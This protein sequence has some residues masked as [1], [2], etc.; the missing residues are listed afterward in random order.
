MA[1]GSSA[2]QFN[3]TRFHGN[4]FY[5]LTDNGYATRGAF[6]GEGFNDS[7]AAGRFDLRLNSPPTFGATSVGFRCRVPVN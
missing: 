6:A 5:L 3:A 7:S 2:G 4:S 1:I